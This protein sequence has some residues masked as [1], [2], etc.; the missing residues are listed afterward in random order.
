MKR[1]GFLGAKGISPIPNTGN[2]YQQGRITLDAIDEALQDQSDNQ[3]IAIGDRKISHLE[4][5]RTILINGT[6][7][8][9]PDVASA[10]LQEYQRRQ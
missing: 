10:L 3:L 9:A 7:S 4:A 5:L 6:G 8:T 2:Y 1:H